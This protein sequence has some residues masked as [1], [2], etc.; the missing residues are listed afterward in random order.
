MA[1]PAS[2]TFEQLWQLHRQKYLTNLLARQQLE[3][4]ETQNAIEQY[5]RECLQ[6]FQTVAPHISA[7]QWQAR[8]HEEAKEVHVIALSAKDL[9][10]LLKQKTRYQKDLMKKQA[11]RGVLEPK[12]EPVLLW[13]IKLKKLVNEPADL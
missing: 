3:D 1:S 9:E 4:A 10:F 2:L 12:V 7:E 6:F 13:D 8:M 5:D 11:D